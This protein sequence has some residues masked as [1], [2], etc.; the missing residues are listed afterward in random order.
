MRL[1]LLRNHTAVHRSFP[2]EKLPNGGYHRQMFSFFSKSS[3][4][5]DGHE[6]EVQLPIVVEDTPYEG[7]FSKHNLQGFDIKSSL[8]LHEIEAKVQTET[9]VVTCNQKE[10][11]STK[12]K[13]KK[14]LKKIARKHYMKHLGGGRD[15][16]FKV[17]QLSV[18]PRRFLRRF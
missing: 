17:C 15:V 1:L 6:S 10:D 5:K 7:E 16:R 14:T 9:A 8:D 13:K 3:K 11:K 2:S 4:K 12:Y 18:D